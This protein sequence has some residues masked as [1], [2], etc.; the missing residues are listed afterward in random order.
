MTYALSL[1]QITVT[2][3]TLN[4]NIDRIVACKIMMAL[5]SEIGEAFMDAENSIK[6]DHEFGTEPVSH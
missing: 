4:P 5:E 1:A 3:L 2:L 6:V